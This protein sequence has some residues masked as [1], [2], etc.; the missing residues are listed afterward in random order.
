MPTDLVIATQLRH[1]AAIRRRVSDV[2]CAMI[3]L[4]AILPGW[5]VVH[6]PYG[7]GIEARAFDQITEAVGRLAELHRPRA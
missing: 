5:Q 3:I 7:L 6:N 4:S 2:G 1:A